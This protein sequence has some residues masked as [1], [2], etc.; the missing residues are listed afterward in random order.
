[1]VRARRYFN[2]PRVFVLA[3]AAC[4]F[5]LF[6]AD[7]DHP[8]IEYRTRPPKDAVSELNRKIQAGEV[9]LNFDEAQGYLRSV[10]EAL[11]IPIQSQIVVFSKTSIQMFRINPHNPRALSTTAQSRSVGFAVV[12]LWNSLRRTRNKA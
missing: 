2:A 5:G 3:I 7:L 6:D 9:R 12:H 10:L 1:M 11:R 4:A 8:A